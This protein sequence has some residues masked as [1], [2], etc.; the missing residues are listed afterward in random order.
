MLPV[1]RRTEKLL[2]QLMRRYAPEGEYVAQLVGKKL[3][4]SLKA[5]KLDWRAVAKEVGESRKN[6]AS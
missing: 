2:P 3:E 5:A 4:G 1:H 6:A